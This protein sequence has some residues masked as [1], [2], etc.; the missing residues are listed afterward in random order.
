MVPLTTPGRI[1]GP[2]LWPAVVVG[3]GGLLAVAALGRSVAPAPDPGPVTALV[4]AAGGGAM[5]LGLVVRLVEVSAARQ[6][7]L[8]RLDAE[9]ASG[10]ERYRALAESAV[11]AVFTADQDGR[12]TYANTAANL[13]FGHAPGMLVG[14]PLTILMPERFW[15]AHRA[16]LVAAA[17]TGQARHAG[18][19]LELSAVRSDGTEF[20]VELSVDVWRSG[21]ST[22]FS[23]MVRDVSER[24]AAREREALVQAALRVTAGADDVRR[25]LADFAAILRSAV[26]FDSLEYAVAQQDGTLVVAAS[27]SP[28][29]WR[30][31]PGDRGGAPAELRPL[32]PV[33]PEGHLR[34]PVEAA[35]RTVAVIEL[36]AGEGAAI[37][38]CQADLAA[39]L[40]REVAGALQ[41]LQVLDRERQLARRLREVD[42]IKSDFVGMVVHDLRSPMTVIGG[43]ADTLRDHWAALGDAQKRD[44]LATISRN[45]GTLSDRIEDVLQVVRLESG[46]VEPA[47]APVDLSA[48]VERTLVEMRVAW[49]AHQWRTRAV[50][51]APVPVVWA[52]EQAQW[53]ILSNLLTNAAKFSPPDTAVE[54]GLAVIPG[55]V[56]VS[57]RDQ[58]PGIDPADRPK[59]FQ[60]FTR[61]AQAGPGPRVAGTGL[62]LYI[63][64]LLVERQGGTIG[65]ESRPGS[66]ATFT[67]TIPTDT[68]PQPTTRRGGPP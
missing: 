9:L 35:G 59:L 38:G 15:V 44:F 30:Y 29:G 43:Y 63:C 12:I 2:R 26:A 16:G 13:M 31:P 7:E 52:D 65:V 22:S 49:P 46:E 21:A 50:S 62:G 4:V 10:D 48:V 64:R 20:Q 23:A 42:Q 39:R 18:K 27:W 40:V 68:T 53:Q 25:A 58:G 32:A 67:Y 8:A 14:E 56:S 60:R 34:V 61:L 36:G 11:E 17:A 41:T 5:A 1:G 33:A 28:A 6:R 51:G 47:M 54:V 55:G 3:L 24:S 37:A 19:I 45:V 66:G 57:V